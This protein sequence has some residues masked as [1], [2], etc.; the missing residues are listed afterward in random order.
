MSFNRR[1]FIVVNP[2][3]KPALKTARLWSIMAEAHSCSSTYIIN[4]QQE[5]ASGW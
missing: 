1:D 3:G 4:A 5:R 2:H